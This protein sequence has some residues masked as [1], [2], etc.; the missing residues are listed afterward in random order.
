VLGGVYQLEKAPLLKEQVGLLSGITSFVI[1]ATSQVG[2]DDD[3]ADRVRL[4]KENRPP[5]WQFN[6]RTIGVGGRV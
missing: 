5:E 3:M 6:R 1:V 4:H 2:G